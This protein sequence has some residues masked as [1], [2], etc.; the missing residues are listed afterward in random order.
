MGLGTTGITLYE[1]IR[2]VGESCSEYQSG[3]MTGGTWL[4]YSGTGDAIT[5]VGNYPLWIG[6]PV[7]NSYSRQEIAVEN[8]SISIAASSN[9]AINCNFITKFRFQDIN[10]RGAGT[11]GIY[12]TN[13]YDGIMSRVKAIGQGTG[14]YFTI[15]NSP[16]DVFQDKHYL[17]DATFGMLPQKVYI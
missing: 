17:K 3:A 6:P 8:V 13:S 14:L 16:N 15:E 11:Y 9:S 4:S 2:L 1:G 7:D 12:M 5:I 10:I